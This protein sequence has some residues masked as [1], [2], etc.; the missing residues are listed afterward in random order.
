VNDC[1][2]R[3]GLQPTT[4]LAAIKRAYREQV[5]RYHPDTV[6]TPEQKRRYTIICAAINDA[7]R[8]ALR[9]AQAANPT[10]SGADPEAFAGVPHSE[11]SDFTASR[12]A[13][14]D[15]TPG[16]GQ[17]AF[18]AFFKSPAAL[19]TLLLIF[20]G[21]EIIIF[22]AG[23]VKNV[24]ATAQTL[25]G[26]FVALFVGFILYGLLVAGPLDLLIFWFFPRRLFYRLGLAKYDNKI[27]WLVTLAANGFVFFFTKLIAHPGHHEAAAVIL[28]VTVRVAATIMVPL[29]VA[30]LWLRDLLRY[31]RI[32]PESITIVEPG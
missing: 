7:Y 31:R 4:D 13:F 22:F 18:A 20:F 24:P 10:A 12:P 19:R 3:L 2:K 15:A 1:W 30:L 25:A 21:F 14:E 26:I 5:K 9:W 27:I 23:P 29:I 8:E 11:S 17:N 32:K 6:T 16:D 28:D